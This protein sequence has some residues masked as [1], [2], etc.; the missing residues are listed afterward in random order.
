M[1]NTGLDLFS[2]FF[3]PSFL[4]PIPI[5]I[6]V[7]PDVEL[8]TLVVGIFIK[9]VVFIGFFIL[10]LL[11]VVVVVVVEDNFS[12]TFSAMVVGLTEVAIRLVFLLVRLELAG[13]ADGTNAKLG[14]GNPPKS[15]G[16]F[17][18]EKKTL[19]ST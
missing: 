14:S 7:L 4:L 11:F 18:L 19:T 17:G 12:T 8:V 1:T 6:V 2:S 13:E 10:L 9:G 15:E 16:G 3:S 5:P